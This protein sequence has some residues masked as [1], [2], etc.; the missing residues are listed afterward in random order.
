M[1]SLLFFCNIRFAERESVFYCP[2]LRSSEGRL[3]ETEKLAF[4]HT[5]L[6]LLRNIIVGLEANYMLRTIALS[7]T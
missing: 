3:R 6:L 2:R 1:I 5:A 7:L 4:E